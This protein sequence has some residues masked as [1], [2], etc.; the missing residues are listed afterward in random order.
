MLAAGW[1][2]GSGKS[3]QAPAAGRPDLPLSNELRP[4]VRA[5]HLQTVAARLVAAQH[6]G[7]GLDSTL[8]DRYLA[9]VE[10]KADD[11]PSFSLAAV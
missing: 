8:D 5:N 10:L 6:Q 1:Q 4:E 9:F 11:L 2:A 7:S 3:G